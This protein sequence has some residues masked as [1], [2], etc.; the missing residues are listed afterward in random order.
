MKK[1]TAIV[2]LFVVTPTWVPA[3]DAIKSTQKV[4]AYVFIAPIVS[5]SRYLVNPAYYGVVFKPGDP[6]PADFYLSR[7][8]GG[9]NTGF[10][11]EMF[12]HKG[13]GAGVEF[14]YAAP[15][16]RFGRIGLGV[17]SANASYHFFGQNNG[18]RVEPFVTGGYSLYFG[19]RTAFQ[20]GFN[21]GGGVNI[22]M[23]KHVGLRF[24]LRDQD[25]ID[26]FHSP[27]TRFV[28]FRIGVTFR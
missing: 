5:N 14:G 16:W 23:A 7:E 13:L 4:Q 28:A 3:Q 12:L 18:R 6:L 21:L 8:R 24:E 19:D 22:W 2:A 26:Y 1:L 27:F 11:G 9:V 17:G 25:H 15:E 10:G 20:S